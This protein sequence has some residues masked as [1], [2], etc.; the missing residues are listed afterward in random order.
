MRVEKIT[1][2][3]FIGIE[4]LDIKPGAVTRLHGPNGSGK[5]S[6][7]TAIQSIIKGGH[8]IE[9]R[10]TGSE[11]EV[12]EVGIIVSDGENRIE[13]SKRINE[14]GSAPQVRLNGT[15]QKRP[16]AIIQELFDT[17]SVNPVEFIQAK[18]DE[19][20]KWLLEAM[21][22]ELTAEDFEQH[23]IDTTGWNIPKGQSGFETLNAVYQWLYDLRREENVKARDRKATADQ[24]RE[25][26]VDGDGSELQ[27]DM[28][29]IQKE[30]AGVQSKIDN[31]QENVARVLKDAIDQV[32]SEAR[33]QVAEIDKQITALQQQKR[34]IEQKRDADIAQFRLEAAQPQKSIVAWQGE[35]AE[36]RQQY[37]AARERYAQFERSAGV[38]QQYERSAADA[39]DAE[40]RAKNL[41]AAL[42]RL[43]AM[44]QEILGSL[45][46]K[47]VEIR[48]KDIWYRGHP[49]TTQNEATKVILALKV[50]ALRVQGKVPL[51]CVDGAECLDS[52]TYEAMQEFAERE[53]LQLIVTRVTDDEALHV[54]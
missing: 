31:Y 30:A 13:V 11:S 37:S 4:H 23:G 21:P 5:S 38:R 19:Q 16:G 15:V 27:A 32:N 45:P 18:P 14:S 22:F 52:V 10:R 28:E 17:L 47:D 43:E 36:L 20:Y 7:V 2:H 53:G 24:L 49:L 33:V 51:I 50:A 44:K 54:S 35:L 48:G 41:D 39:K 8:K 1:I 12:S 26:L 25:S 29:R 40:K 42:K 3:N 9:Y 6:A 34:E 46:I